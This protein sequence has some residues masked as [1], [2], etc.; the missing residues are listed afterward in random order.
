[1]R[2]RADRVGVVSEPIRAATLI[3]VLTWSLL[4]QGVANAQITITLK[5]SFIE[6]FKHRAAIS[7]T[8]TVDKAKDH[9]NSAAKDGDLHVAGRAPEIGLATV[10]EIMNA[11]SQDAAVDRVHSVAGKNTPIKIAGAWRLWCEHGGDLDQIQGR[12]LQPFTT[13]NPDHVF[14]IHPITSI[15]SLVL[16][17]SLRPINGFKTKDA[18]EAF[19]SYE[20][21]RCH[22]APHSDTETTTLNTTMGGFNYVEFKLQLLSDKQFPVD[23]GRMVFASVL[24]LDGELIIRKRRMVFVKDSRPEKAVR[25]LKKGAILHVLGLPRIDLALVS[26]RTKHA[27]ERPE[28]LDW[29]LPYEIIVVGLYE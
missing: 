23:D 25:N 19:T 16:L 7:A 9:P 27:D 29:N 1:M 18:Q 13:T 3:I 8:F 11:A 28:V 12:P 15:D 14:E 6:Q 20:N 17:P 22:I 21:I 10:A 4:L 2:S 24:D 26:W 5:N